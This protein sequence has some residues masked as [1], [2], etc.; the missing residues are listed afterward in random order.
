[1]YSIMP[2]IKIASFQPSYQHGVDELLHSITPEYAE[3]FYDPLGKKMEDLYL[4]SGRSYWVALVDGLVAGTVGVII[5]K[6][7]AILK[8]LFVAKAYR[9]GQLQLAS[10]LLET[11]TGLAIKEK[12]PVIYLGTMKQFEAAQR[13]YEKHGYMQIDATNMPA[14]IPPNE[15]DT[16]FYKKDL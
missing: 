6:E 7:Y 15:Y 1:M 13:F 4:L 14:D 16:V 10:K 9:G 11:A 3:P 5:S 12:C 8:S 2:A